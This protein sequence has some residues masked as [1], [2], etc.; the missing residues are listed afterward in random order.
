MEKQNVFILPLFSKKGN[1]FEIIEAYETRYGFSHSD[2]TIIG[3]F[4]TR[5][6]AENYCYLENYNIINNLNK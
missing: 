5:Q 4:K 6:D 3:E 2:R 1:S